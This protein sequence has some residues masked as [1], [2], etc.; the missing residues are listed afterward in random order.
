MITNNNNIII[1]NKYLYYFDCFY[2]TIRAELTASVL[3]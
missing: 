1:K 3:Q 2:L